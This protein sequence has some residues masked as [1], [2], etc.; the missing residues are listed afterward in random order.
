M[1]ATPRKRDVRYHF[2][3]RRINQRWFF[4][5]YL[6]E[7][8]SVKGESTGRDNILVGLRRV[9]NLLEHVEDI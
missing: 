8:T 3:L 1:F 4:M 6:M 5:R 7:H 9:F 2:P